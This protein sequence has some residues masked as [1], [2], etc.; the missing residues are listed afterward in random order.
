MSRRSIWIAPVRQPRNDIRGRKPGS[1]RPPFILDGPDGVPAYGSDVLPGETV[2]EY[3][4]RKGAERRRRRSDRLWMLSSLVV[5]PLLSWLFLLGL[6]V[7]AS[8][9]GAVFPMMPWRMPVVVSGALIWPGFLF[10]RA[11][12]VRG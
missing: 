1:V 6:S 7:E 5:V 2:G 11:R 10:V 3:R 4:A 12:R 8:P 9:V